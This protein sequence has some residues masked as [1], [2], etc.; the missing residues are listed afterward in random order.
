MVP[1]Y[2]LLLNGSNEAGLHRG[3]LMLYLML[4]P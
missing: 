4:R 1:E 2:S 3:C